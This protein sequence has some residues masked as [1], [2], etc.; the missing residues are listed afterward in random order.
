MTRFVIVL[1]IHIA[2]SLFICSLGFIIGGKFGLYTGATL[3]IVNLISI[4]FFGDKIFLV[5]LEARKLSGTQPAGK[6][7][8]N[9][10]FK[11][12]YSQINSYNSFRF[13][14]SIYLLM[15]L[16]GAPTIV[17]GGNLESILSK[18]E[19]DRLIQ[20]S[21]K[22]LTKGN[23]YFKVLS[24]LI[25]MSITSPLLI[26]DYILK[27][28]IR[29]RYSN[30]QI[31]GEYAKNLLYMLFSPLF[32]LKNFLVNFNH[33]EL[34]QEMESDPTIRA[35]IAKLNSKDSTKTRFMYESFFNDVNITHTQEVNLINMI[36]FSGKRNPKG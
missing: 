2:W 23:S 29:N 3:V 16:F 31:K 21:L 36:M 13:N 7:I 30:N 15:P 24:S 14:N 34:N 8:R 12:G 25:I 1:L 35:A 20:L 19:F 28:R 27:G 4:S 26:T 5:M 17:I 6:V 10:C 32:L 22:F 33:A 11:N 18:Q 9:Y